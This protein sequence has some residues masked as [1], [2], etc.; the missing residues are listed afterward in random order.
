MSRIGTIL[1]RV[2]SDRR[3]HETEQLRKLR[4]LGDA[5][6][7]FANDYEEDQFALGGA[8][9]ELVAKSPKKVVVKYNNDLFEVTA[10]NEGIKVNGDLLPPTP[11]SLAY[12]DTTAADSIFAAFESWLKDRWKSENA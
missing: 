3:Q 10:S 7:E 4:V 5:L 8:G 9:I 2:K 11:Q 6:I 12:N 1:E